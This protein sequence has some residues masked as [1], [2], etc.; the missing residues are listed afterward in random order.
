MMTTVSQDTLA[1]KMRYV[2]FDGKERSVTLASHCLALLSEQQVSWQKLKD[3]YGALETVK[4]R[5]LQLKDFS[6]RLYYNPGRMSSSTAAVGP[7]DVNDRPCFLCHN[8]LPPEQR[9][10]LYRSG[11]RILCNPMPVFP[12]HFTVAC[13]EHQPQAIS[14]SFHVF[15]MLMADLGDG[16]MT[17][18]NGP[19][20]GASAPDHLHFQVM[21]S[22]HIPV[23]KEIRGVERFL[24]VAQIEDVL[25]YRANDLGREIIVLEG[26]HHLSMAHTFTKVLATLRRVIPTKDEPMMNIAG[27]H[28]GRSW[29]V[30]LFPRQ[31]HRPDAFYREGDERILVSPGTVEMAGVLI[32]PIEKD[33][34]RLDAV[35]VEGIYRE[36]SLDGDILTKAIELWSKRPRIKQGTL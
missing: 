5:N 35:T 4:T 19:R 26:D 15:L 23:E 1:S 12:S 7:R 14:E 18:Y 16:W 28:D 32:A 30:A 9:W 24:L 3:A 22:G 33:F 34:E 13:G 6:I 17:L 21:P 8:N 27:F 31:K 20:C 11:Y 10:I 2:R 29:R 25:V 36:V